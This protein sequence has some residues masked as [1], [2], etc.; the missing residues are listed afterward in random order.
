MSLFPKDSDVTPK[1]VIRMVFALASD[2]A[3]V[4]FPEAR[5]REMHYSDPFT[6][7]DVWL[8]GLSTAAFK[9]VGEDSASY[10]LLLDRSLEPHDAFDLKDDGEVD[11]ETRACRG[12]V[13]RR[14]APL[15][16]TEAAHEK[17]HIQREVASAD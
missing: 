2:E 7:F 17:I 6:A 1:P 9:H 4:A 10:R 5:E 3:G 14:M 8:A 13:R 11:D 12:T 15:T 16:S